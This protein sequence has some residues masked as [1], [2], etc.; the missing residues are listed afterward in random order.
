MA[1]HS[2][3]SKTCIGRQE[4]RREGKLWLACK[5]NKYSDYNFKKKIKA[6]LDRGNGSAHKALGLYKHKG[7]SLIPRTHV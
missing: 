7:M 3:K 4:E 1:L 5:I 2:L 6:K